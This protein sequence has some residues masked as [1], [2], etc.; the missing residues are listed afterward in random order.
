MWPIK[1]DM[2]VTNVDMPKHT[3]VEKLDTN[4][5]TGT[6]RAWITEGCPTMAP[7]AMKVPM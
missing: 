5:R 1:N 3:G 4:E 6:G 7:Q 2:H